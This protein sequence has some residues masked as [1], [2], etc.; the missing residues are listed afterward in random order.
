MDGDNSIDSIFLVI[1]V[2][3]FQTVFTMIEAGVESR[4]LSK[5]FIY[6]SRC[7]EGYLQIIV[8]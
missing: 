7:K 2:L 6:L 1:A 3:I 4:L 5:Y 8:R